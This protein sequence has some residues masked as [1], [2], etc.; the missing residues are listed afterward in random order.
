MESSFLPQYPKSAP[1]AVPEQAVRR[2]KML[3]PLLLD[4]QSGYQDKTLLLISFIFQALGLVDALCKVMQ[5][6]Q[7]RAGSGCV[8]TSTAPVIL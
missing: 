5:D 3:P 1:I 8:V 2:T 6:I 4:V 7:I